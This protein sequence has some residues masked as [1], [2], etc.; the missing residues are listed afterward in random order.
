MI[1]TARSF[2]AGVAFG[3][4]IELRVRRLEAAAVPVNDLSGV[5]D[6]ELT[7]RLI[8]LE[9]EIIVAGCNLL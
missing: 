7:A 1:F 8:E 6:A 3:S 9:Q 5:G 2:C 4:S